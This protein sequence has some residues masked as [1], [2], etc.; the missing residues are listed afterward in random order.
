MYNAEQI[1]GIPKL[2][3]PVMTHRDKITLAE[4]FISTSECAIMEKAQDQAFYNPRTDEITLPPR[5]TFRSPEAF[6]SVVIHEMGHSTGHPDRLNRPLVGRNN[7]EEY[8]LEE[9]NAEIGTI[10]TESDLGIDFDAVSDTGIGHLDYVD[11]WLKIL[12]N[13]PTAFFHACTNAEKISNYLVQN[14]QYEKIL[15]ASLQQH[16]YK[17]TRDILS[18]VRA[19]NKLTKTKNTLENVRDQYIKLRGKEPATPEQKLIKDI[20]NTLCQQE[21]LHMQVP[22]IEPG[23]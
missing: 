13:N 2:T 4:E 3:S 20:G 15:C 16:G 21:Q 12:N 6:L 5:S 22:A 18:N 19:L 10:F 11:S 14:Y 17:V 1:T 7:I 8:A 9:L 23:G